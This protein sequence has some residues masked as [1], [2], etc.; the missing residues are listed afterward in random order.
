MQ[1]RAT[2][3]IIYPPPARAGLI[4]LR[5]PS[6]RLYGYFDP[7]TRELEVKRSGQPPERIDLK[8]LME[9]PRQSE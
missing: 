3:A 9:R 7:V 8:P 4:E 6:G 2:H 5:G 1:K